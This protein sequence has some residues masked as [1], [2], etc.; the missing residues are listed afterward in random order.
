M[1]G[2]V[3][4]LMETASVAKNSDMFVESFFK[5]LSFVVAKEGSTLARDVARYLLS[6]D[7][8]HW[9]IMANN[10][11][12]FSASNHLDSVKQL[13]C[14][15]SVAVKLEEH[16]MS[17]IKSNGRSPDS[18]QLAEHIF[19]LE[20]LPADDE[21]FVIHDLFQNF[22][23]CCRHGETKNNIAESF[24]S[25]FLNNDVRKLAPPD[26]LVKIIQ[27][28]N[29][30]VFKRH[31]PLMTEDPPTASDPLL[32]KDAHDHHKKQL[33]LGT[34]SSTVGHLNLGKE[35]KGQPFILCLVS[36]G[37]LNTNVLS[38]NCVDEQP[39][40]DT[41]VEA[42]NHKRNEKHFNKSNKDESAKKNRLSSKDEPAPKH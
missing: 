30:R 42:K 27:D 32:M 2:Q 16:L 31:L 6:I 13:C 20:N 28:N 22:R 26:S 19:H 41:L 9:T 36:E 4:V 38:V 7:P 15:L 17:E 18:W 12:M 14:H 33:D 39:V 3:K 8:I 25:V 40:M 5:F 10:K 29:A 1:E 37:N 21:P 11:R 23:Q 24:G 35:N 34:N